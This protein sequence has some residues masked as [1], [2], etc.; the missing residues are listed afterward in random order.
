MNAPIVVGGK[1]PHSRPIQNRKPHGRSRLTNKK[2]LLPG[3][4]GRTV[5]YRRFRDIASQVA[6]DQGG[7]D[8]L[9]E[10]RLQLVRRFAAAAVPGR[11]ARGSSCQGPGDQRRTPRLVMQHDDAAGTAHW[12]RSARQEHHAELVGIPH[13]TRGHRMRARIGIDDALADHNLLGSALGDV[14]S[15]SCWLSVLRATFARPMS[16]ADHA[17]FAEVAGGRAPPGKRVNEL[18]CVCGRRS[19]KTRIAAAASV[20]IGAIA[21]HKLAPGEVGYVLLLAA[22]RSQASVA[23]Q[24]VVGFLESSPILRQQVE[25]VTAEEVRLRGN[26]VIG[27]HA[28]SY[29][30]IR[31]RTLLAV[32]GDETAFWRDIDSAQPDVEVFRACAP[33]L[34]ASGGIWIGISTGYRKIGLLYQK[35]RDH[36]GHD[37]DDVLVVQGPSSLFNSSLDLR[38]IERATAADPEA[39]ES[40]WGGGFR[41]DI[42]AFLS[43]DVIER[44]IDHARPLEL[45]PRNLRYTAF[46]DPSGGRHDAFTLCIGHKEGESFVADVVR[47]TRAPFDPVEV[48]RSYATLLKDYRLSKAFGDNYSAEWAVSAF[49]ECGIRY[50]R[51]DKNKSALYLEALPLFMRGAIRIPDLPVLTRELRLL[52]RQTHR[53]GRDTIDHGRHGMDDFVNALCGCAAYA[54]G[55]GKYS[56]DTSMRWVG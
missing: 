5:V 23:F 31:G 38:M 46:A 17:A 15:W 36:F 50:E 13:V 27:V 9:S 55:K 3:V 40:E 19:G 28:G 18:W 10:A 12:H 49:K 35:W 56:Y 11:A 1:S 8:Q 48:T 41:G 22:S 2:D 25:S 29:R 26:I 33:A 39:A 52:E 24:Y 20:Y 14:A 42:N 7:I 30:T 54:T 16:D 45:P 21:Q 4:D 6:L 51:A 37:G 53:S 32:V 44:A 43:D 34:A 47:G